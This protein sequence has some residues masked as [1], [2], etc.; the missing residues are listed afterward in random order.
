MKW[1]VLS[2]E[3]LTGCPVPC[4]LF[5]GFLISLIFS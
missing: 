4:V 5:I 1:Y 3:K 2:G